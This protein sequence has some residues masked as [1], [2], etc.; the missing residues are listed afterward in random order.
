MRGVGDEGLVGER[1]SE[2]ARCRFLV[3]KAQEDADELQHKV[4]KLEDKLRDRVAATL[5][6]QAQLEASL[7]VKLDI[8]ATLQTQNISK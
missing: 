6:S 7:S 8:F 3:E 4:S 5:V 1:D 2:L